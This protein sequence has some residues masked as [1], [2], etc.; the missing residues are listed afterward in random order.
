M[1]IFGNHRTFLM[2][3]KNLVPR[4]NW[5]VDASFC[6]EQIKRAAP[7]A[8]GLLVLLSSCA[9]P[10]QRW[11]NSHAGRRPEPP[12]KPVIIQPAPAPFIKFSDDTPMDDWAPVVTKSVKF[13]L[14]RK[15]QLLFVVQAACPAPIDLKS[16]ADQLRHTSDTT[17]RSLL[18]VM[19]AAGADASQILISARVQQNIARCVYYIDP[20]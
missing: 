2:M 6:V 4:R 7:V 5:L 14:T 3:E 19:R 16:Q 10:G 20:K 8:C 9:P 17:L 18:T 11:F 13:A 1:P 12:R 15:A